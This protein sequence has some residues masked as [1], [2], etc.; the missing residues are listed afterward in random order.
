MIRI[1]VSTKGAKIATWKPNTWSK[2]GEGVYL[3]QRCLQQGVIVHHWGDEFA[4]TTWKETGPRIPVALVAVKSGG[5]PI[6]VDLDGM[7][8]ATRDG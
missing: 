8:T 2:A 7:E 3:G 6:Y 1:Y 4:P 5:K